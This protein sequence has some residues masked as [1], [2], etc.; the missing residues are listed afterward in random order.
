MDADPGPWPDLPPDV[1]SEPEAVK[2][3]KVAI[4]NAV[5]ELAKTQ[6]GAAE[7]R[8]KSEHDLTQV[9]LDTLTTLTVG[10][11]DRARSSAQFVQTAATAIAGL[12]TGALAAIFITG[13]AAPTRTL[14]PMLFLGF[15]I[16]LSTYYLAFL[17]PGKTIA[18]PAFLNIPDNDAWERLNYATRWVRRITMRRANALRAAILSL[19]FG[20]LFVPLAFTSGSAVVENALSPASPSPSPAAVVW[21]AP[22]PLANDSLSAVLYAAQLQQFRDNLAARAKAVTSDDDVVEAG[23]W[24]AGLV[25]LLVVLFVLWNPLGW[26]APPNE[27]GEVQRDPVARAKRPR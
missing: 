11:V 5:V 23:A 13:T 21:P 24:V 22:T 2:A 8:A 10:G 15:S 17:T 12:Y 16:W 6:R 19:L 9:L 7:A 20:L 4:A 27:E 3:R 26:W 18:R 14:V 25:A 1:A